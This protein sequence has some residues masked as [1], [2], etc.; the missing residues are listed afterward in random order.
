MTNKNHLSNLNG[1]MDSGVESEAS[2]ASPDSTER[3]EMETAVTL[4]S[5]SGP[6]KPASST[7]STSPPP[8]VIFPRE[9]EEESRIRDKT[10]ELEFFVHCP[11]CPK[12]FSSIND[13]REH[14][15][16]IHQLEARDLPDLLVAAGN[17]LQHSGQEDDNQIATSTTPSPHHHRD[18]SNSPTSSSNTSSSPTSLSHACKICGKQF[19]NVYRLQRHMISHDE[20]AVLR[21]FKCS[22]CGKAFKFK[23][24]L[25][26]HIRIHTGDKP[27]ECK[28]CGKRFSHSGSYSSHMTSKKCQSSGKPAK[29]CEEDDDEEEPPLHQLTSSP[30]PPVSSPSP[31]PEQQLQPSTDLTKTIT[32]AHHLIPPE[33][34]P[35]EPADP[36]SLPH[37]SNSR[38]P[39][40]IVSL[41]LNASNNAAAITHH[42]Q[43]PLYPPSIS[44][45]SPHLAVEQQPPLLQIEQE[46]LKPPIIADTFCTSLFGPQDIIRLRSLL[47]CVNSNVTMNLLRDNLLKW[48]SH[49]DNEDDD[50]EDEE[51]VE[52]ADESSS[53]D[54]EDSF[55]LIYRK[56]EERPLDLSTKR[57]GDSPSETPPPL[58]INSDLDDEDD[59]VSE[60]EE[61]EEPH[62]KK[63]KLEFEK[64]IQNKLIALT[65]EVPNNN[66]DH[67]DG[68]SKPPMV[69]I[70]SST[71]FKQGIYSCDLCDK[72]FTKK[73]SITRHKYEHSD[74]R[75]HKCNECDKAFKHKHHLTEHKRLHSGEKP[76]QCPKCLKRFSH[77]GSYSQHINHRFSYC[78]PYRD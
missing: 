45:S 69:V 8:L 40:P 13:F 58:V 25:K 61:D 78:K 16:S 64:M 77:S 33:L 54:E 27:F 21:R 34:L 22:D 60:D 72:K 46:L 6:K 10:S 9:P 4:L 41:V 43:S 11:K 76:F 20:S 42:N 68:M 31:L 38:P 75:P 52:D 17:Q 49:S 47:E 57:L 66:N 30:L 1:D 12:S 53:G 74:Q 35:R 56:E 48:N 65:P 63:S 19:A 51:D 59:D 50:E 2:Q 18:L 37:P 62:C 28:H 44:P 7:S 67:N 32:T 39:P 24:H 29:E 5:L 23:H 3:S 71:S 55:P 70:V 14:V 15:V 36:A 26:E 73:S